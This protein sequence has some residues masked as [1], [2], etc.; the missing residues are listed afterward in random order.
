MTTTT[1]IIRTTIMGMDTATGTL[2]TG[3]GMHTGP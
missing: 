1:M 2:T 3:M